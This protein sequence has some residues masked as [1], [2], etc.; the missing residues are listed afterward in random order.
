VNGIPDTVL[1]D[2]AGGVRAFGLRGIPL[3]EK[4]RRLLAENPGFREG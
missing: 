4:V 3:E 1:F 2:R